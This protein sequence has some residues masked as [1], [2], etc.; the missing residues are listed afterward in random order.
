MDVVSLY[1]KK[2]PTDLTSA[3]RFYCGEDFDKA[4]S[5]QA[6][7]EAT[8]KVL[9]SQLRHYDDVAPNVDALHSLCFDDRPHLDFSGKFGRNKRGQVTFAFGKHKNKVVDLDNEE[10]RE[11][12]SW[13]TERSNPSVEMRMA[14]KRVTSQ[15]N[16]HKMCTEWLQSKG[17]LSSPQN[18]A[19]LLEAIQDEK[20]VYPFSITRH[21]KKLSI[22]FATVRNRYSFFVR[23]MTGIPHFSFY[24]TMLTKLCSKQQS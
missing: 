22:V 4:H 12:C 20:D 3:V 10:I 14:V 17:I 19:A 24:N 8:I 11:Y 16:C 5:A 13:L 15:H 2:E 9:Q 7:V 1:H 23:K 6:D 18:I 21:G